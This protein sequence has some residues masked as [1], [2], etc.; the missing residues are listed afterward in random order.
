VNYRDFTMNI[1]DRGNNGWEISVL[2]NVAGGRQSNTVTIPKEPTKGLYFGR[3]TCGLA[4]HNAIP[5]EHMAAVVVS[6][7]IPVL[8]QTNIMPFWWMCA[9]WQEPLGKD[10]LAECFANMKLIRAEFWPDDKNRYCPA[11]S[12]SRKVGHPAKNK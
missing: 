3:C 7:R 5:C 11:W 12:A 9:Q 2:R 6:S 4:Q 1:I 10:V 8:S